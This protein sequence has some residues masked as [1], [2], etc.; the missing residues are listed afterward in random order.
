MTTEAKRR[1][2]WHQKEKRAKNEKKKKMIVRNFCKMT[3]RKTEKKKKETDLNL[4]KAETR[5]E[6]KEGKMK[7]RR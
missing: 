5:L 2:I 4:P 1:Y 7:M 3:E 6:R